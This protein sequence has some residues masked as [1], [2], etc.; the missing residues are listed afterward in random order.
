MKKLTF[1]IAFTAFCMSSFAQMNDSAYGNTVRK[2]LLRKSRNQRT[3]GFILLG[4][5]AAITLVGV[6]T[7][8]NARD[9]PDFFTGFA[10]AGTGAGVVLFGGLTAVASVP[11]FIMSGSNKKKANKI[12]GGISFQRVMHDQVILPYPNYYPALTARLNF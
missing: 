2:D 7:F 11:F 6:I 3:T 1:L 10:K 5:G 8:N 12:S 4:V 9:S